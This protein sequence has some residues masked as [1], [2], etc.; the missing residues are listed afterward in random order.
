MRTKTIQ[1]VAVGPQSV[2]AFEYEHKLIQPSYKE[3][4]CGSK[5]WMLELDLQICIKR[6]PN[7]AVYHDWKV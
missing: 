4:I 7:D 5:L 1:L 3:N 6:W 2:S